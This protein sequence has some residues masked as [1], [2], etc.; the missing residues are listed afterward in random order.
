VKTQS[1][2]IRVDCVD[3]DYVVYEMVGVKTKTKKKNWFFSVERR[4]EGEERSQGYY[5]L[6]SHVLVH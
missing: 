4:K 1:K 6:F 3:G 5:N 2:G